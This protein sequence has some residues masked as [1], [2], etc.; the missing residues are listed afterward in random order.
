MLSYPQENR[1]RQKG[2][3]LV[4]VLVA[5]SIFAIG[6][7]MVLMTT[8]NSLRVTSDT[9]SVDEGVN[10]ARLNLEYLLGLDYNDAQLRDTNG[11]GVSGLSKSTS[12]DA[13]YSF[14]DGRYRVAW[15]VATD[16]PVNGAKTVAVIVSWQGVKGLRKVAFQTIVAE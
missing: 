8:T 7:L 11:D 1:S 6:G 4:E 5:I 9:R 14:V 15:N 3:S 10:L 13:D 2:V 16:N 12:A